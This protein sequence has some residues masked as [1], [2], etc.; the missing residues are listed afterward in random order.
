MI[1]SGIDKDQQDKC[2][3]I[4]GDSATCSLSELLTYRKMMHIP[5][6][7]HEFEALCYNLVSTTMVIHAKKIGH[8]DIRPSNLL[9][10]SSRK[11]F[12]LGGLHNAVSIAN[13]MRGLG[14]NLAG[15]PYYLPKYL[16][17]VARKE[18]YS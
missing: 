9:Y 16:V 11:G 15:V 5:W 18:E 12:V 8:R 4:V 3:V 1:E 17:E 7:E 14:Y 2:L 6:T 10:S 13:P